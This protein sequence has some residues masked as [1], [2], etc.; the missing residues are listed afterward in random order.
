MSLE[1]YIAHLNGLAFWR[2]FTFAQNKFSPQPGS[3]LEL[4]DN[5]V[6]FGSRAYI[7]QLKQREEPTD[8]ANAERTWFQRKVLR[9]A[10][11]QIRDSLRFLG[12]NPEIRITNQRGHHFEIRRDALTEITKV[13]VFLPS[14][15]LPEDCRQTRYHV[16]QTAGF[17]HILAANDYLGILEKLRVP[18]D[19]A[20][21]FAYREEV[22]PGLNATG[23]ELNEADIMGAFLNEEEMPTPQSHMSLHYLVQDLDSFDLSRLLRGIHDHINSA[24]RP[25]DYYRIL[26]E[27]AQVPRSVWREVKL[28]FMKSLDAARDAEF[29]LPFRLTFPKTDCTFMI[30]PLD[31]SLSAIGREGERLRITGLKNFTGAAMYLAKSTKGVG[32]LISRDGEYFQVDWCLIDMPWQSDPKMDEWLA[33]TNPFREVSEKLVDSFLFRAPPR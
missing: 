19:I 9:K 26:Q 16:S 23:T 3:E 11:S 20:R 5:L 24:D 21:Y 13:V 32:I 18:E 6:W 25:Y 31:P 12:E 29:T 14:P 8:D 7:L 27:F 17:I 33:T 22:A 10:T 28:R 4:A 1:E 15:A 30:A 2:E